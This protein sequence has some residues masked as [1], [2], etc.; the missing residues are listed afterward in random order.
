VLYLTQKCIKKA[1]E[2]VEMTHEV[3]KV[4]KRSK[5]NKINLRSESSRKRPE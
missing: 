5:K 4:V 3:G 1:T 2:K